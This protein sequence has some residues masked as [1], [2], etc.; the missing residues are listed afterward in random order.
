[1]RAAD[2]PFPNRKPPQRATYAR[3]LVL[4]CN[5]GPPLDDK[6]PL[7]PALINMARSSG[8]TVM[9]TS[10]GG[11]NADLENTV[12]E[13]AFFQQVIETHPD[14]YMQVRRVEAFAKA[15]R[16]NKQLEPDPWLSHQRRN[17]AKVRQSN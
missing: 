11:F 8:V 14:V 7:L 1:M 10:I 16:E 3:A 9:K 5:L 15:K 4:D 17:S 13:I 2:R 6:L 12:Q